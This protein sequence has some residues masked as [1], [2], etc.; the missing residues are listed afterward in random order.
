MSRESIFKDADVHG[1][2]GVV[3]GLLLDGLAWLQHVLAMLAEHLD[4]TCFR[5][6]WRAIAASLN[7]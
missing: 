5:E 7:R 6:S 1:S 3:S 2:T 4:S